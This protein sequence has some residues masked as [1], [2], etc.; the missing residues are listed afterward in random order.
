MSLLDV[1]EKLDAL[2]KVNKD[3]LEALASA[4]RAEQLLQGFETPFDV[5]EVDLTSAHSDLLINVPPCQFIQA[6]CDGSMEGMSVKLARQGAQAILLSECNALPVGNINK[7][8]LT[9]DV[10]LGRSLLKLFFSRTGLLSLTLGGAGISLAELAAR[11]GALA[12][13]D[14]RGELIWSDDFESNL[15]KWSVDLQGVGASATL[16][17]DSAFAGTQS[18]KLVTGAAIA[19]FARINLSMAYPYLTPFGLEIHYTLPDAN[20]YLQ[21]GFSLYNGTNYLLPQIRVLPSTGKLQ[22]NNSAGVYTD[23]AT[24][25]TMPTGNKLWQFL[26]LVCDF[27]SPKYVRCLWNQNSYDLSDKAIQSI[28]SATAP[29]L[30]VSISVVTLAAANK[31][32]YIDNVIVT[33]SEP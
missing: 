2:I 28:A 1:D 17:S 32:H 12:T 7:L 31:T 14:R 30:V 19:D 20:T 24:G 4:K 6:V 8:Y 23:F 15:N 3:I 26:K 10:R 29:Q 5:E 11:L 18:A 33:Q 27:S 21:V 9:N 22:Y 13:F 25:L 16:S